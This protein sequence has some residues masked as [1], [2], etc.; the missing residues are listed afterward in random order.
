MGRAILG[1]KV[2]MTQLF[3]EDGRVHPVTV[4]EAGPC[5]VVQKKHAARHGYEAVQVGFGD[6]RER[7]VNKPLAG[8]YARAK[9][10]PKRFLREFRVDSADEFQLGQEIKVD[11]WSEGDRVDVIG[12]SRGRGF[13]GVVKR[14]GFNRGP[15]SHGSMYHRRVGALS[16]TDPARVFKGR[17]MPGR[18]G[19]ERVTALG[20]TVM[21]VD[22]ERNLLLVRGSVPGVRG[23]LVIVRDSVKA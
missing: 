22:S 6:K 17:K 4:I 16:A 13:A 19:G 18:L 10:K 11:Q 15:M 12:T 21:K 7:L 5:Y 20:L 9:V 2:G 14:W 1:R 23:G 8:H 3:A